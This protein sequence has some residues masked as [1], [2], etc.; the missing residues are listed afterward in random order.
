MFFSSAQACFAAFFLCSGKIWNRT[1]QDYKRDQN[2][3]ID[4]NGS[5]G[6][7]R[8]CSKSMDHW[9]H[10]EVTSSFAR[11]VSERWGFF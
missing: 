6:H 10:N 11:V 1:H 7:E 5:A 3:Q 2:Y 9:M 8:Y 4:V